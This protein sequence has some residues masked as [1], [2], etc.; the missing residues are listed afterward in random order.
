M[1]LLAERG[2]ILGQVIEAIFPRF[3]ESPPEVG[4]PLFSPPQDPF[5]VSPIKPKPKEKIHQGITAQGC[6]SLAAE[7][8]VNQGQE[9]AKDGAAPGLVQN[10]LPRLLPCHSKKEKDEKEQVRES[11]ESF[12]A[13]HS[14]QGGINDMLCY[15]MKETLSQVVE[16][17]L[18]VKGFKETLSKRGGKTLSQN[19]MADPVFQPLQAALK[20][21]FYV[22][23]RIE[24]GNIRTGNF[25]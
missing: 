3:L 13:P 25:F 4:E 17:F 20:G 24:S 2:Q 5:S 14:R 18:H 12:E 15:G 16:S 21:T 11:L 7:Q 1:Y 8:G 19:G 23:R 6:E 22:F 9:K 10:A